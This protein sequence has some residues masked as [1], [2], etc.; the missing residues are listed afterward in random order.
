MNCMRTHMMALSAELV[1]EINMID[2]QGPI[3]HYN[4]RCPSAR[5]S[6]L[7]SH[8]EQSL[9]AQARGDTS[10]MRMQGGDLHTAIRNDVMR[11]TH[12]FD[13]CADAATWVV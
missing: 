1:C 9:S 3:K 8:A 5:Q 4:R 7:T 6:S 12:E 13:W 2:S 10:R 11:G